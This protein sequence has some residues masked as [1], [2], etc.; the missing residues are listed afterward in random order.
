[1]YT[2]D[3]GYIPRI[4]FAGNLLKKKTGKV[5]TLSTWGPSLSDVCRGQILA[6]KI[7]P[8][9]EGVKIFLVAVDPYH[10]YSNE[11]ERAN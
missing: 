6:Y 7:N 9:T 10:R 4:L 5:L 1:M 8:R 11:A 3:G 2:P